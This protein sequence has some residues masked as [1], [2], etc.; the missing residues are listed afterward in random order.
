MGDA[1]T[2]KAAVFALYNGS[3]SEKERSEANSWLMTFAA[4]PAAW[5]AAWKLLP[6]PDEQMSYFG[7]NLLFTKVRTEWHGLPEESKVQ[8][9]TGIKQI[10]AQAAAAGGSAGVWKHLPPGTKRLCLVLAAAAV[11]SS[12]VENF[13]NDALAMGSSPSGE[14]VA[15]AVELL[16]SL[17]QEIIEKSNTQAGAVP[18]TSG[19]TP[20][21]Q[22]MG[23][24]ESF[25]EPR[26]ELRA[27]LPRVL[28]LL[29]A[30]LNAF[31]N[32]EATEHT[33]CIVACLRCLQQWL[34]LQMGCSMLQLLD[35]NMTLLN[36]AIG[37]LA[38]S[39]QIRSQA[40][41]D[42]LVELMSA[43]NTVLTPSAEKAVVSVH[44]MAEELQKMAVSMRIPET[45]ASGEELS[46]PQYNLCRV[47]CAF[48]ERAVDIIAQTDGRL[49]SLVQ[50][51][52]CCL[53]AE[54]RCTPLCCDAV[55]PRGGY[56]RATRASPPRPRPPYALH[57]CPAPMPCTYALHLP[58]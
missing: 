49:L 24:A 12:A 40:A 8:L 54:L 36:A 25:M 15:V 7:A 45:V 31:G 3:S 38:T 41:A 46:E 53:G 52:F 44:A 32:G 26:S 11:R 48:A 17:P 1:E 6:E 21:L 14:G 2:L 55:P 10:V 19:T 34:S 35:T 5:E 23:S 33:E 57:L 58:P 43:S 50:L 4:S 27:F 37:S 13:A 47:L 51:L 9:Y 18:S 30:S 56:P 39:N 22:R 42:C 29:D 20:A 16:I 28:S